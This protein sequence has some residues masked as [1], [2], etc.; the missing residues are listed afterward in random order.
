[1][2]LKVIAAAV[3]VV[4]AALSVGVIFLRNSPANYWITPQELLGSKDD[5]GRARVAGQVVSDSIESAGVQISFSIKAKD[6][7]VE[8]PVQYS[9][10]APDAFYDLSEVIVEGELVDGTFRADKILVRCPDNYSLE[11]ASISIY[12]TLGIEGALYR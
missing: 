8:L 5:S 1:M 4:A 11:K 9:G 3:T 10:Y 2:R 7:Q 12:K 6:E